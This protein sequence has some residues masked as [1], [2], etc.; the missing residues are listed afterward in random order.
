[1][2]GVW[3]SVVGFGMAGA[4]RRVSAGSGKL[5]WG[6]ASFG[7]AGTLWQG[8]A[9]CDVN[10]YVEV[11]CVQAWHGRCGKVC[12]CTASRDMVVRVLARLGRYAVVSWGIVWSG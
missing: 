6:Q 12:Q 2:C 3:H 7:M 4:V 10:W 8:S 11:R 9:R 5:L 1:M